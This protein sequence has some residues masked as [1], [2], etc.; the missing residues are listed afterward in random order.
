MDKRPNFRKRE[1]L[2]SRLIERRLFRCELRP[3]FPHHCEG[4]LELHEAFYTRDDARHSAAAKIYI[5]DERNCVLL[6]SRAHALLGRSPHARAWLMGE[7]VKR[8]GEVAMREFLD[9]A[10]MRQRPTLESLLLGP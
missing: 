10:P 2:K 8:Y 5:I 7:Q 9:N 1:A 3:A 6:C 4:G